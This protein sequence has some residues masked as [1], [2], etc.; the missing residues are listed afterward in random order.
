MAIHGHIHFQL[1]DGLALSPLRAPFGSLEASAG[2]AADILISFME[3]VES[4]LRNAGASRVIIKNPPHAYQPHLAGTLHALFVALDYTIMNEEVT[5]VIPVSDAPYGGLMHP[6]KTRKLKHTKAYPFAFSRMQ[7]EF[8]PAVYEFISACRE[9]KKYQLSMTLDDLTK[10]FDLFP[11]TYQLFAVHHD[12]RLVAAS[13]VVRLYHDVL[14]HFMSDHVRGTGSYTPA[15]VLME[16]LYEFCVEEKIR[17]LD[18]GTSAPEQKE[19]Q[20]LIRFKKE[21]G[22]QA[23]YKRTYVKMLT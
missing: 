8:L 22:G 12:D 17:M 4:Q 1:S 19:S 18:L 16:G 7:K 23:S 13:V 15:L 2:V 9:H 5:A 11:D 14:Y 20:S 10:A 6:R 3:Y 21:L